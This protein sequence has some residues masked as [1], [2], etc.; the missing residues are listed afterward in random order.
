MVDMIRILVVEDDPAIST[1]VAERCSFE[2][3]EVLIVNN[4]AQVPYAFDEFK[5]DI[6]VLDIMLPGMNGFE[7]IKVIRAKSTVP[8]IMLTARTDED[9]EIHALE[10]GADDY[11]TKP[12]RLSVLVAHIR[13]WIKRY[14]SIRKVLELHSNDVLVVGDFSIDEAKHLVKINSREIYNLTDHEFALLITLAEH[15]GNVLSRSDLL[16]IVW[17]WTGNEATRTVDSHIK[18]LRKKIGFEYIETV[19]GIGYRF[20]ESI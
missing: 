2:G 17:G 3:W 18:M 20:I 5:P 7:I 14:Q 13:T 15:S 19:H 4:G 9:D 12:L 8:I 1:S 16:R 11:L 10:I 6:V